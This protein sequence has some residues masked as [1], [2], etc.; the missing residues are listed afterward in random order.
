MLLAAACRAGVCRGGAT[1]AFVAQRDFWRTPSSFP[2]G[3]C[4]RRPPRP[5][6]AH[7]RPPQ[8][9][10]A[11]RMLR[12]DVEITRAEVAGRVVCHELDSGV[13]RAV[14]GIR[15]R[16]LAGRLGWRIRQRGLRRRVLHPQGPPGLRLTTSQELKSVGLGARRCRWCDGRRGGASRQPRQ[17]L[18]GQWFG[19]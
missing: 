6:I 8:V 5:T 17:S 2:F 16:V 19:F 13:G 4:S 18:D 12:R 1:D 10:P 15:P 3:R 11:E 9:R 14:S 7:T